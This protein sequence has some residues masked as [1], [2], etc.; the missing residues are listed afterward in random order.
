MEAQ[1]CRI[2]CEKPRHFLQGAAASLSCHSVL[3]FVPFLQP[4]GDASVAQRALDYFQTGELIIA[5]VTTG[6]VSKT[7]W[8]DRTDFGQRV[9]KVIPSTSAI[10]AF[11][12]DNVV[13]ED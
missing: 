7:N 12:R 1:F 9:R 6:N 13:N 4:F 3:Y 8:A 11:D 10:T 2:L 5:L